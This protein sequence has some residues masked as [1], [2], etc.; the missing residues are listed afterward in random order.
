MIVQLT[1]LQGTFRSYRAGSWLDSP[2]YKHPAPMELGELLSR[3]FSL[4]LCLCASVAE[5]NL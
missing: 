1:H 3:P 2:G 5:S 4:S